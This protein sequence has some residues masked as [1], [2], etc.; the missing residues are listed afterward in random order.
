MALSYGGRLA[1]LARVFSRLNLFEA[2]KWSI[3]KKER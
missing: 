1:K 2:L 3:I